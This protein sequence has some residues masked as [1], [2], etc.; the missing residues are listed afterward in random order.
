VS[1]QTNMALIS[2]ADRGCE[3]LARQ[4]IDAGASLLARELRRTAC[5]FQHL[6]SQQEMLD[7]QLL[8]GERS[9]RFGNDRQHH[10]RSELRIMMD[11]LVGWL[12][13]CIDTERMASIRVAIILWEVAARRSGS[14][15]NVIPSSRKFFAISSMWRN[16][17]T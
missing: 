5:R 12:H 14:G 4:L 10:E 16:A 9:H 8:L 6:V 1:V 11:S 17:T 3:A 13:Y 7:A 2:A 15:R